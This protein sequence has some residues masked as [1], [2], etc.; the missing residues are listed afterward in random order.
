MRTLRVRRVAR[1]EI[2]AAFEWYLARS[3]TAA[4]RFLDEVDHAIT[5]LH[6]NPERHAVVRGRLRRV[7]L[8]Q[9]PYAVYYKVYP[10]T[11]SVVGVI[12]G[13]RHPETWLKRAAP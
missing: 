1:R 2:E 10:A 5:T 13:H 8:R 4:R 3:P 7:L 11:I 9:F 6:A 12:H